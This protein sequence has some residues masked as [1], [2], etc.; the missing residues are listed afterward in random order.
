MK[1][2]IDSLF[3]L[4]NFEYQACLTAFNRRIP[5]HNPEFEEYY[6]KAQMYWCN[7]RGKRYLIHEIPFFRDAL[8]PHDLI[9][10]ELYGISVEDFLAALKQIQDSLTLGIGKVMED[11][12]KFR[13]LTLDQVEER[14]KSGNLPDSEDFGGLLNKVIEDNNW[15]AW[16]E[17]IFGR[18]MGLDLFDLEKITTLPRSILDDLS[19]EPGQN[20]EF[21]KEGNYKG[22]PLRIWPI[23]QR[24]F[25]KLKGRYYSFELYNLFDNLYRIIQR[26][27]LKRKPDYASSWNQKQQN[28]P[29]DFRSS[30]LEQ[31][32]R[33]PRFSTTF[34]I[35]G[36][37]DQ[38]ELNIGVRLMC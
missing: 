14:I 23:F 17:D 4:L 25:I 3:V 7:V 13:E 1:T 6:F 27:L 38:V 32:C 34:I 21:F 37:L 24:P 10:N 19:W 18:F 20:T 9:L 11:L 36:I 33:A 15:D 31:Y 30:Y 22:W 26:T 29:N 16:R 5:G 12:F 8:S 35:S 2:L 28:C